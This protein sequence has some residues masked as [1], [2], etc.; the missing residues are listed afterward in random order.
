MR[1]DEINQEI[2]DLRLKYNNKITRKA[3]LVVGIICLAVG[4]IAGYFLFSGSDQQTEKPVIKTEYQTK[5]ETQFVYVPK[6]QN[7]TTDIDANIGKQDLEVKVNGQK[8]VIRK[9]DDEKFVFDKNKLELTQTSK[10]SLDIN[11]P[12]IDKTKRN[13]VGLGAGVHEDKLYG[14]A[15]Y[16]RIYNK[17]KDKGIRAELHYNL[18][19]VN[20]AEVE[21]QWHF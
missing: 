12:T 13:A 3:V 17:N 16:S 1:I 18:K 11:V 9:S 20:G 4:L 6:E 10:A 21:H 19:K 2:A 14:T 7:E 8:A 15:S 5:T